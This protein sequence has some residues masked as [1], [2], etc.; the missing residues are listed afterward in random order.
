MLNLFNEKTNWMKHRLREKSSPIPTNAIGLL[1]W[2]DESW[3]FFS[4]SHFIHIYKKKIRAQTIDIIHRTPYGM[5]HTQQNTRPN[6]TALHNLL[7]LLPNLK[8]FRQII[9]DVSAPSAFHW[10]ILLF[11]Y[12]ISF[13]FRISGIFF[14]LCIYLYACNSYCVLGKFHLHFTNV[15]Q[16]NF[17]AHFAASA[18]YAHLNTQNSEQKSWMATDSIYNILHWLDSVSAWQCFMLR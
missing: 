3:H 18:G 2:D 16:C 5:N 4:L 17:W 9:D 10:A 1:Y 7:L 13:E 14:S 12:C 6:W 8:C 15:E 11:S